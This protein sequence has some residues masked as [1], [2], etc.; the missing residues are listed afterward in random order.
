[1][2]LSTIGYRLSAIG[3]DKPSAIQGEAR[4]RGTRTPTV[5]LLIIGYRLSVIGYRLS[6]IGYR[7]SSI[8]YRL[9]KAKPACAR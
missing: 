6:V 8:G 7:L 1:M 9:C 4:L 5:T 2:T 3:Y